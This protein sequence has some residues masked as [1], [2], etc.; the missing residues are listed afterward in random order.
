M[1]SKSYS[2]SSSFNHDKYPLPLNHIR[3]TCEGW[4]ERCTHIFG[5]QVIPSEIKST[6]DEG[7]TDLNQSQG[8]P[9]GYMMK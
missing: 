9:P 1:E 8:S 5:T 6:E 4:A 3:V 2:G 7:D